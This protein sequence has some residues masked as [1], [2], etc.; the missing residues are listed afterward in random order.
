MAGTLTLNWGD[1]LDT[2]QGLYQNLTLGSGGA[3]QG[4]TVDTT[5]A[6]GA[7]SLQISDDGTPLPYLH[8]VTVENA[9]QWSIPSVTIDGTLD[10]TGGVTVESGATLTVGGDWLTTHGG[11]TITLDP[12]VAGQ[13]YILSDGTGGNTPTFENVD[14]TIQ[15]AGQIGDQY[16]RIQN[17]SGGVI[18]ANVS[19][20]TLVLAPTGLFSNDGVAEATDGGTL[21]IGG[22]GATWANWWDG[23]ISADGAAGASVALLNGAFTND[24]LIQATDGTQINLGD[25]ANPWT[26]EGDGTISADASTLVLNGPFDN[27]G[28]I[29]ATDGSTLDIYGPFTNEG[30]IWV[31]SSQINLGG[32]LTLADLGYWDGENYSNFN[33]NNVYLQLTGLMTLGAG[34]T[35]DTTQGFFRNL[36]VDGG[37]IDGGTVVDGWGGTLGFTGDGGVLAGATVIGQDPTGGMVIN[38]GGVTLSNDTIDGGLTLINGASV[39]L[40]NGTSVLD[41]AGAN[42]S[43]ITVDNFDPCDQGSVRQP[44]DDQRDQRLDARP[45]RPAPK[46][47]DHHGRQF[48]RQPRRRAHPRRPRQLHLRVLRRARFI[49]ISPTP[50]PRACISTAAR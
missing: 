37:E 26:N 13:A 40:E 27:Q 39:Y 15:G 25:G 2:T 20:Q 14:N 30:R 24:G 41:S 22:A 28:S 12:A 18:D 7:G 21:Q 45:L 9:G 1:T 46:R 50:A 10:N 3:I 44:G 8:D 47:W 19:G 43:T 23:T 4:G 49:R 6:S 48:D 35:L 16:L 17:D 38:G 34:D 32:S 42:P 11:G 29:N 36:N 5:S 33:T 31:D